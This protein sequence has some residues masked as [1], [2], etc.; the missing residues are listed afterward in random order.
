MISDIM[1]VS[2]RRMI[3]AMIAGVRNPHKQAALADRRIKAAPKVLDDALHGR[4]TDY[5][6]FML[7]LYLGQHDALSQAIAKIDDAVDAATAR[8]H[9]AVEAG[10]NDQL[11]LPD[12]ASMFRARHQHP[13]GNDHSGRNRP[14]HEPFSDGW[15][16]CSHG[17]GCVQARTRAP[18]NKRKSSRLRKGAPWLSRPSLCNAPGRPHERRDS[19]YGAQFKRLRA[20]RGPKKAICAVAASMLTAI[21]HMLRDGTHHQDLGA[22]HFDRRSN[23][24]KARHHVAQL[25]RLGFH[26]ELQPVAQAA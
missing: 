1:G 12:H 2:G 17:P 9:E 24:V 20:K 22:D 6:R 11:S 26:V 19:Y 15:A 7:E 25:A 14:R 3:E 10:Q 21:Y 8:M 5:H 13:G 16:L 18:A 4:L 23:E